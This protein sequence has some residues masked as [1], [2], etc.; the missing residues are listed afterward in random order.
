MA[1]KI[2][3]HC[4]LSQ[5]DMCH[6]KVTIENSAKTRLIV[7]KTYAMERLLDGTFLT[8]KK[9]ADILGSALSQKLTYNLSTKDVTLLK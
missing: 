9:H 1:L 4:D 5:F 8:L 6:F 7:R 2:I 3:H